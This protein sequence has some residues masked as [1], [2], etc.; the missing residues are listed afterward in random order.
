MV[1]GFAFF[2]W[3][4]PIELA[5]GD[6]I[7]VSMRADLVGEHY[8]WS[9]TTGIVSADGSVRPVQ[10]RQSEFLG[11][12]FSAASLRRQAASHVPSLNED[13]AIAGL[14]LRMMGESRSLS[15]IAQ[16]V[17]LTHPTRFAREQDALTH[18]AEFSLRYGANG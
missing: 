2:P 16:A 13:G 4:Q 7:D 8:L 3:T 9:W 14:I 6:R 18:V 15:D 12:P 1:Y 11:Q 5:R 17:A 10:M